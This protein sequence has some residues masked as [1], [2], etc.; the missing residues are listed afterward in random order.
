MTKHQ[1]YFI[2]QKLIGVIGLI[3][4]ALTIHWLNGDVAAAVTL[5]IPSL[6]LIF[7]KKMLIINKYYVDV[8]DKKSKRL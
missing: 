5:A 3:F 6:A 1:V 7:S 8:M 4:A 2:K